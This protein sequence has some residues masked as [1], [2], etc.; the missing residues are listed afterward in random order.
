MDGTFIEE[1]LD[2]PVD[3]GSQDIL[4][5]SSD[6]RGDADGKFLPLPGM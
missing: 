6:V 5:S 2:T 4:L 3:V 1:G